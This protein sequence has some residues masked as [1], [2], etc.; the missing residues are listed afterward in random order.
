[1]RLRF[2]GAILVVA[3]DGAAA[4]VS[5]NMTPKPDFRATVQQHLAA[6][7]QH[8]LAALLRTVTAGEALPLVLPN[9]QLL[10][11]RQQYV[12]LHKEWFAETN[13][14]FTPEIITYTETPGMANALVRVKMED[15][16]AKGQRSNA[17]SNYLTLTF[18]Q[19]KGEWR[20]VF[21][22]NTRIVETK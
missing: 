22:Q 17:R 16:D 14:V 2:V 21:D 19:E 5:P 18:A 1:M 9:G 15:L 13:W 8:D 12:D 4:V 11:T 6:I 20:L 3:L 10:R 7:Q